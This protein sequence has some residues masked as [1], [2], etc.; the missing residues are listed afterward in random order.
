[1]WRQLQLLQ[2][3]AVFHLLCIVQT[4]HL[5]RRKDGAG[6]GHGRIQPQTI[7]IIADI[8]VGMDIFCCLL[9]NSG[10]ANV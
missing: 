10:S 5:I 1:L 6:I 2:D 7:K 9:L 4:F 8:V 3:A